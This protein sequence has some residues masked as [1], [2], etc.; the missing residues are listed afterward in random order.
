MQAVPFEIASRVTATERSGRYLA[1]VPDGWQQG[2]GAFGGLVF[3]IL[4]R[5][6]TA[7]ENSERPLR[8]L[9][10]EIPSPVM[11]GK[12]EIEVS[13]IRRG[14]GVSSHQA[15]LLQADAVV[16]RASAVFGLARE[17]QDYAEPPIQL[18]THP[19]QEVPLDAPL[20]SFA[21][22]V[23]FTVTG[24]MPFSGSDNPSVEGWVERRDGTPVDVI[25]LIALA[26]AYWPALYAISPG[27]R[28]VATVSFFIHL[29]PDRLGNVRRVFCRN[30]MLSSTQ[31]FCVEE[32]RLY[33]ERGSL[34]ALNA[35]TFT[36]IR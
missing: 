1:D 16:A 5:A 13:T 33:C 25:D 18:P 36:I 29:H 23:R 17:V 30:Q 4:A 27:P 19:G 6:M 15:Q 20:P 11:N 8:A 31:G 2:R 14:S 28:P 12:T 10:G 9:T 24:A 7:H 32:R 21:R 34:L 3:G 35:Q 26:D 22:N